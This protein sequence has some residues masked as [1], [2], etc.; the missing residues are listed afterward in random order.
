MMKTI[1]LFP[2]LWL[3]IAGNL[4]A[5]AQTPNCDNYW[6]N[7]RTGK[8]ECLDANGKPIDPAPQPN[9]SG[10]SP[11]NA[12]PRK[13]SM[14]ASLNQL[15][16]CQPSQ[17]ILPDLPLP[18]ITIRT[19]IKGWQNQRCSV[20]YFLQKTGQKETEWLYGRCR[21]SRQT[22]GMMTDKKAYQ[23]AAEYDKTGKLLIN[24]SSSSPRDRALSEALQKE[25]QFYNP[26]ASSK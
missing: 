21:Y 13:A 18:G 9:A 14:V 5:I 20:D 11:P 25:C 24:F 4:P 16:A 3:L 15:K 26:P 19:Q 7:P 23:D 8:S 17:I 2:S 1:V 22:V 6:V 12:P 10:T